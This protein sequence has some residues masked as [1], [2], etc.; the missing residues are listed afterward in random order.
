V[1]V[2]Y[3]SAAGGVA[4]DIGNLEET[5][6]FINPS[7]GLRYVAAKRVGLVFSSGLMVTT[8]GPD[9]RKSFINF[10][11]GAELKTK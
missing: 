7:I 11:L 3:V 5:R 2:P 9:S 1:L 8:G 6:V 4:L 10:R